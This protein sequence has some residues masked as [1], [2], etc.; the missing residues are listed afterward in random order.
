VTA[1]AACVAFAAILTLTVTYGL[2][3]LGHRDDVT[4]LLDAP[5]PYGCSCCGGEWTSLADYYGHRC[6]CVGVR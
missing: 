3:A 6:S 2:L 1:L 5:K 4:R